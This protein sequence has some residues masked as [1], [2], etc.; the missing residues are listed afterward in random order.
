GA[1]GV[2]ASILRTG[3]ESASFDAVFVT[4][5]LH[6]VQPKVDEAVD[7]MYRLLKPGGYFCFVEPHTGS[8]ADWFR[9]IWYRFDPIFERNERA[10]DV[11]ALER[12]NQGRFEF[13]RRDYVGGI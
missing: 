5:G 12:A 1:I 9:R 11:E 2:C 3:L 4:G 6:H 7:E 10:V 13:L 8:I